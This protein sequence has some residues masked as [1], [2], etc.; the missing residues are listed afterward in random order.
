MSEEDVDAVGAIS[1]RSGI[2]ICLDRMAKKSSLIC[3]VAELNRSV[4]GFVFYKLGRFKISILHIAVD[5]KFRRMGIATEFAKRTLSKMNST[6]SVLEAE[7]SEYNLGAQLFFKN[8]G[9]RVEESACYGDE[10]HY[11]F[12][13]YF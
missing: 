5:P 13:R 12:R 11:I 8:S 9:L 2:D 7:V 4:K 1:S 10:S 6:R 3:V